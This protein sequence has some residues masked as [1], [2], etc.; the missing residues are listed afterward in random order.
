MK[1]SNVEGLKSKDLRLLTFDF[2]P[3]KNRRFFRV[4]D[5]EGTEGGANWNERRDRHSMIDELAERS[6][7]KHGSE[8][9]PGTSPTAWVGMKGWGAG[10]PKNSE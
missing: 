1:R 2:R 6:A 3:N 5:V 8:A 9:D 4:R 10:T 7:V